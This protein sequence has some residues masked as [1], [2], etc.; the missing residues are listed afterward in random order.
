M[1]KVEAKVPKAPKAIIVE[2]DDEPVA[3]KRNKDKGSK[4]SRR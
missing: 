2:E 3:P 1:P 4:K